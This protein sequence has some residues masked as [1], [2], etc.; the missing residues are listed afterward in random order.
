MER[1]VGQPQHQ[2]GRLRPRPHADQAGTCQD[3]PAHCTQR[4][5][6]MPYKTQIQ[7]SEQTERSERDPEHDDAEHNVYRQETKQDRSRAVHNRL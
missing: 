2:D 5:Q 3:Q 6:D 7:R 1:Q 4:K